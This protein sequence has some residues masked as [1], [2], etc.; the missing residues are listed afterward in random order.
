[1]RAAVTFQ[2]TTQAGLLEKVQSYY[3]HMISCSPNP[4]MS[5][6]SQGAEKETVGG[7]S[8]KFLGLYILISL[9]HTTG[10]KVSFI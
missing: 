7:S 2:V 10:S 5:C 3:L 8:E 9:L 4:G 6:E 1:V